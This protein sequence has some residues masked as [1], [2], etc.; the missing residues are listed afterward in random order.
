MEHLKKDLL[1]KIIIIISIIG[2]ITS[3]YLVQQHYFPPT[4]GS[5]CDVNNAISC[6]SAIASSY[7]LFLGVPVAVW[8]GIWFI[9][10]MALAWMSMQK[11]GEL[12]TFML[13]WLILGFL[14]VI[15][16]VIAEMILRVLCPLCTILHIIIVIALALGVMLHKAL[17][18]PEHKSFLKVPQSWFQWVL[19]VNV[20][21]LI[22]FNLVSPQEQNYDQLAQCMTEK[23]VVMYSSFRCGVCIK[24]EE[25]LGESMKY[26]NRVECHPQGENSQAGL[27]RQ[28]DI[29]GTPTWIL[30]PNG[31]EV[32]RNV[33]FLDVDQLRRFSG[34][35]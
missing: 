29:T 25:M 10:L 19:I 18:N 20:V 14:F 22:F 24:S 30:E 15:Y 21:A 2:F 26:I 28:K 33:G 3:A 35:R 4:S 8:S 31:K 16:M 1:L 12:T 17:E 6:S 7:S 23:G 13:S 27:C 32:K 9:F 11:Q 34:C 5:W